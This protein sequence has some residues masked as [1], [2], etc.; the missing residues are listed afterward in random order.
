MKDK[1]RSLSNR[2]LSFQFYLLGLV[3]ILSVGFTRY[4]VSRVMIR[5][6]RESL[7]SIVHENVLF[8][9][10]QLNQVMTQSEIL[11]SLIHSSQNRPETLAAL[12]DVLFSQ[13]KDL[14][15]ICIAYSDE[16]FDHTEASLYMPDSLGNMSIS[17]LPQ[18]SVLT[19]DWYQIPIL[20][21]K[22]YWSEPWY[23]AL[24]SKSM[25]SSYSMPMIHGEKIYGVIRMDTHV[26]NFEKIKLPKRLASDGYAFLISQYGTII[27]HPADSLVMNYS[28][29]SL[30]DEH[31]DQNLRNIGLQMIN[32]ASD[33]IH[34]DKNTFIGN[35]WLYF[36]PLQTNK[37]SLAVVVGEREV[38]ADMNNLLIFL[39]ITFIFVFVVIAL[40]TYTRT[41][42]ILKPLSSLSDAATKIGEGDFG[43]HLPAPTNVHEIA[44]LTISFSKM[45]TSL[46]EYIDSLQ[47]VTDEKDKIHTEVIYASDVQRNLIPS[48]SS[49]A[50]TGG[51]LQA[52]GI[53][54]PAGEVGGDLY[55]YF[56]WGEKQ[57]FFAIADVSGKG[58]VA[59]MTMTMVTTLLRSTVPFN[60]D[61]SAILHALN[62]FLVKTNLESGMITIVFG[63]IDLRSGKLTFSN[64][65]H[66]P[67]YIRSKNREVRKLSHTHA[68]ALGVF[69]GITLD[70]QSV[71]LTPGDQII[72]VTD[73]ITEALNSNDDFFGTA[74]LESVINE[75]QN[76]VAETT[77]KAIYN[78]VVKHSGDMP[79]S[80]D[81]TIL[82][83]DFQHPAG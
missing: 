62:N 52:Y 38:F 53:L 4:F 19:N 80:D 73:G 60:N 1:T 26:R 14:T 21:K 30:A 39:G 63:I 67:V 59:A 37:W 47:I 68:T 9:D 74:G 54:E 11:H 55:D 5:N 58:I 7:S 48:N 2:I 34:F 51:E 17:Q 3:F 46:K 78:A 12:T 6:I 72:L 10:S 77:A 66:V 15:S 44:N 75:M 71:D 27:T 42:S 82:V 35:K 45:Q 32:G 13:N 22:P 36:A 18:A 16:T 79:Q 81:I 8:I 61:P 50:T 20:T 65:G 33:F 40:G 49:P 76:P 28:V 83:I 24:G 31:Q 70:S 23:D 25:V 57:F 41:V 69:E 64:C 43:V 56:L 29:F